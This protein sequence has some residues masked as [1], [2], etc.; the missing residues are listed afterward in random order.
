MKVLAKVSVLMVSVAVLAGSLG[1]SLA[2]SRVSESL[3]RT[4]E[5]TANAG[6]LIAADLAAQ[7]NA[8]KLAPRE[9]RTIRTASV[10]IAEMIDVVV[11]PAPR[12]PAN[13]RLV[14]ASALAAESGIA[15]NARL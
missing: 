8:A 11:V 14:D 7:M 12:L 5:V 3:P 2:S 1:C 9:A 4:A 15:M 6:R 10:E 13:Q